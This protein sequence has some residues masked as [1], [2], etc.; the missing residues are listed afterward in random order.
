MRGDVQFPATVK[1]T[2]KARE[3]E[4]DKESNYDPRL[5]TCDPRAQYLTRFNSNFAD[6]DAVE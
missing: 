3:S 6:E 2:G 5:P 4:P 1:N